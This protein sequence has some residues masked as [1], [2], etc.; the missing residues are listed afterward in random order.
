VIEKLEIMA[1]VCTKNKKF[2]IKAAER[3]DRLEALHE[4]YVSKDMLSTELEKIETR[5]SGFITDQLQKQTDR[6]NK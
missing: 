4:T 3:L 1:A 2:K 6:I 5:I